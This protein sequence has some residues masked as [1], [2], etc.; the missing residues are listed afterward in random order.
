MQGC[1]ILLPKKRHYW[2]ETNYSQYVHAHHR[3]DLDVTRAI[4]AESWKAYLP[5]FDEVMRRRSGHR[6]NMFVMHKE[7]A[8]RYCTWLF[9]V[10][11]ELERRLDISS[12]NANDARVV[13]LC[14]RTPAGRLAAA[15]GLALPGAARAL[16]RARELAEKGRG[17]S[18]PQVGGRGARLARHILWKIQRK[19]Q[20]VAQYDYLIVGAGLYGRCGLPSRQSRRAGAALWWNGARI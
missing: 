4:L 11:F 1:D 7:L 15:G 19:K 8:Q 6:F 9:A 18:A 13:R 3:Q 2:I 17:L 20:K 16:H 12:Y 14:G 5:A 10:L